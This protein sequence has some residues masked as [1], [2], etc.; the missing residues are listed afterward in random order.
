MFFY[1][2]DYYFRSLEIVNMLRKEQ[3][4]EARRTLFKEVGILI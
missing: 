1:T 4:I 3:I 2:V